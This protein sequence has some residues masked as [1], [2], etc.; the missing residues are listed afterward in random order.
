MFPFQQPCRQNKQTDQPKETSNTPNQAKTTLCYPCLNI[1][2]ENHSSNNCEISAERERQKAIQL[3]AQYKPQ[4]YALI[5]RIPE[6]PLFKEP[7]PPPRKRRKLS[8]VGLPEL[9]LFKIPHSPPRKRRKISPI[10][11]QWKSDGTPHNT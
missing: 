8:P 3:L 11:L 1:F 6:L 4:K 9:P 5:T 10:G 7:L 2:G